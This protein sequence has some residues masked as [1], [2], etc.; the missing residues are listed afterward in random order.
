MNNAFVKFH[1][2]SVRYSI[3]PHRARINQKGYLM[4]NIKEFKKLIVYATSNFSNFM[5]FDEKRKKK[6]RTPNPNN[7]LK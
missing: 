3:L 6:R 7:F 4:T 2:S 5:L 1:S